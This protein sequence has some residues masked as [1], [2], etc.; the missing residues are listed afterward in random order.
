MFREPSAEMVALYPSRDRAAAMT[1]DMWRDPAG[2]LVA[3]DGDAL[4]GF[5]QVSTGEPEPLTAWAGAARRAFGI[6]GFV[7]LLVRGWPRQKVNLTSPPGRV[8][9][10]ELRPTPRSR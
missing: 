3:V 9:L 8:V 7:R 4:L 2:F 1:V 6:V 5:A 10:Q